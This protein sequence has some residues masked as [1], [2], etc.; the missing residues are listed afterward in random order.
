MYVCVCMYE[1]VCVYRWELEI[2]EC[3]AQGLG[4]RQGVRIAVA[5]PIAPPSPVHVSGFGHAA[6]HQELRRAPGQ[7]A[8]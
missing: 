4:P 7:R 3:S 1:C 5:R 2:Q 8:A 6:L